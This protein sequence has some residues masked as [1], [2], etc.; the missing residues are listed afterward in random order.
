MNSTK[1]VGRRLIKRIFRFPGVGANTFYRGYVPSSPPVAQH[2]ALPYSRRQRRHRT[3]VSSSILPG[4]PCQRAWL[5]LDAARSRC[6]DPRGMREGGHCSLSSPLEPQSA[7]S[8]G[9][10]RRQ[11]RSIWLSP[12]SDNVTSRRFSC[13]LRQL[14]PKAN[15]VSLRSSGPEVLRTRSPSV[16]VFRAGCPAADPD[17][18]MVVYPNGRAH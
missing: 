10:G 1:S 2:P 13:P 9:F 8:W 14:C 12:E 3:P 6:G 4:T 16:L 5:S 7:S 11:K 17:S 15:S 18:P